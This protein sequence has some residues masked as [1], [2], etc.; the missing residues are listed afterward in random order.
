MLVD[1]DQRAPDAEVFGRH[2]RARRQGL[3][4]LQSLR[5]ARTGEGRQGQGQRRRQA[6]A[7][8]L[9]V[10]GRPRRH[11]LS[12][13]AQ[14]ARPPG[15]E[16][17]AST[18]RRSRRLGEG[19]E[20]GRHVDPLSPRQDRR[21]D[22][23]RQHDLVAEGEKDVDNLWRLGFA[24]TCNAHGASELGKTPKW[25]ASHSAQLAGADISSN[26]N[27]AAG[28]AHAD[29]ICKLSLGVAK[30]V[31]R[32]D[33]RD[34]WPEISPSGDVSDWL[35]Q[36]HGREELAALIDGAPD[37]AGGGAEAASVPSPE[38]EP[39]TPEKH[40]L[41]NYSDE[42]LA[43][44]FAD[45]HHA[46]LRFVPLWSKWLLWDGSR[47]KLDDRTVAF[48]RARCSG[49]LAWRP[50]GR[51]WRR[52]GESPRAK[53]PMAATFLLLAMSQARFPL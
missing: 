24:A 36:G 53:V 35:T 5:L 37:Y 10:S 3:L 44:T 23:R 30:R 26:D 48:T 1:T 41:P 17:L 39:A 2:H 40:G 29:T 31:R 16:V 46:D 11:A 25:Y 6:G 21:G 18:A 47:W 45:R 20:G 28:Y 33:L 14:S 27:D 50:I 32:L 49:G 7:D 12:Q 4:G 42:A 38:A 13:G 9:R 51:R 8:N 34:H 15:A 52:G 19:N 43:L 22:R